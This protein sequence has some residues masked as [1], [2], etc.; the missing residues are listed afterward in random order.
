MIHDQL[1]ERDPVAPPSPAAS[2]SAAASQPPRWLPLTVTITDEP[3]L[4]L[5]DTVDWVYAAYTRGPVTIT[6][7][8]QPVS[9]GRAKLWSPMDLVAPFALTEVDTEYRPGADAVRIDLAARR[10][11]RADPGRGRRRARG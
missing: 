5:R 11:A 1:V 10:P 2:R 7:G 6:L 8:R 3:T 9:F 4:T